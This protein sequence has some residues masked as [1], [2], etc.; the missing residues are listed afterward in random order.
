MVAIGNNLNVQPVQVE[1]LKK[2]EEPETSTGQGQPVGVTE[3]GDFDP[4]NPPETFCGWFVDLLWN[5]FGGLFINT[6]YDK[7]L[8]A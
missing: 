8:L 7:K 6:D 2:G 1:Q 3:V 4:Q 5:G